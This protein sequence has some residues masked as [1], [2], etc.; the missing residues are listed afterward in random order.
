MSTG[1]VGVWNQLPTFDPESKSAENP[2]YLCP[3]VGVGVSNQLSTFDSESKSPK[4]QI[5]LYLQ[6]KG[7]GPTYNF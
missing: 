6:G 7:P 3:L 5:S 1:W 4:N 2:I